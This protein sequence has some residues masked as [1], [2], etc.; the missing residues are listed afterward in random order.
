MIKPV[1]AVLLL[2]GL[3]APLVFSA[4]AIPV[5]DRADQSQG[6]SS[7]STANP[8]AARPAGVT[9]PRVAS[10]PRAVVS[11]NAELLMM[12]S[13]LQE[14]VRFLRGRV[15]EQQHQLQRLQV[16]QRDRY[17]DLDRRLSSLGQRTA[18]TPPALPSASAPTTAVPRSSSMATASAK[19]TLEPPAARPAVSDTQAYKTAFLLVRE[20]DFDKAL[21]AFESFLQLYPDSDLTANV[22]Y[23]TGEVQRARPAPDQ[24]KASLAYQQL[25]MRFP[26]NSKAADAHYKL[27]LSYQ[28]LGQPNKAKASMARVIELFPDRAPA[29]MAQDFL[30]QH[31]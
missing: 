16:D 18:I 14:E 9:N 28:A 1:I 11:A 2:G 8:A 27:G 20:R 29:N 12:L 19:P 7:T 4:G 23:W 6:A 31:P 13:Q 25:L 15:E 10:A 17:R 26:T 24:E 3:Y 5:E 22:L 30:R 21:N